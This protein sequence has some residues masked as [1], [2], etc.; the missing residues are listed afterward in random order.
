MVMEVGTDTAVNDTINT[1]LEANIS[2]TS[3]SDL[4]VPGK[5]HLDIISLKSEYIRII[6]SLNVKLSSQSETN[7]IEL[8][9]D[10]QLKSA[11]GK[12]LKPELFSHLC[13]LM[14][15]VRNI[16]LPN[17]EKD[18]RPKTTPQNIEL[19]TIVNKVENI[20]STS[21]TNFE[22]IKKK[23]DDL[24]SS[25]SSLKD[26]KPEINYDTMDMSN[27]SSPVSLNK[28][29][30]EYT[31][32]HNEVHIDSNK[33]TENFID[34]KQCNKLIDAL[35]DLPS[36]KMRGRSTTSFGESCKFNGCRN[37]PVEFP[38]CVKELMDT[39]NKKY[40]SDSAKLNSCLVTRYDGP[41]SFI[42]SH[43]DNE[44]CIH[45]K[46]NIFT[47]SL[48]HQCTVKFVDTLTGNEFSHDVKQGSLYTMSRR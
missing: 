4:Y 33:T 44:R 47:V 8:L 7:E 23:L 46:S 42:P 18:T 11:L 24:T 9:T 39:L 2:I 6:N 15:H 10:E 28:D 29:S 30:V 38:A 27:E 16:C 21:K 3:N 32:E 45:A 43:S 48:G 31:T 35:K 19:N 20:S 17:Y 34:T 36:S 37:E 40:C 14:T 5:L 26:Y 12:L 22:S 41:K 13:V 25:I 1:S